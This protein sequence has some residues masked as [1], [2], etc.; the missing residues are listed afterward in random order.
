MRHT[1]L[2]S[3]VLTA[4]SLAQGLDVAIVAAATAS[5]T[6]CRFTDPQALL[7]ATGFF[8]SVDII[9]ITAA[10][11]TLAALAPY[12]AILTWSNSTYSDP[13]ATGNVF[14]DYVDA[15]GGVVVCM[16]AL[17]ANSTPLFLQG[18]WVPNYELVIAQVGQT[19]GTATLGNVLVPG[20]PIMS[21][22]TSFS[23]GTSSYRP[24]TT[25]LRPGVQPVAEWSDG[26]VLVA[27]GTQPNRADLTFYPP[28]SQCRTDFWDVATDGALLM[29]NA[30]VHTANGAVGTPYCT[31][32]VANSTGV[33]GVLRATGSSVVASNNLT[34]AVSS[35]P[36]NAFGFFLTSRTQGFVAQPGGSQ[37]VLCL[38]GSIGRYVGPGQI[39]NT[40][41]TGSFEL[42]LDLMQTPTPTG[43]V[44]ILAGETWNFTSWHRDAVGGA[45]TSNFTDGLSLGFQ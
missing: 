4:S 8:N 44:A 45:A 22:V 11:P 6:D 15:G 30:L 38:G 20:H 43:P 29:A 13:V 2:L 7:L 9:N 21:G 32:G 5:S 25:A 3:L 33:P 39:K 12:D 41:A 31:P 16:F 28:S 34:L 1:V 23:G 36:L 27:V 19:V 10:P 18:R 40:G 14:A 26:R 17:A 37:G 24:T 42:V 35:L